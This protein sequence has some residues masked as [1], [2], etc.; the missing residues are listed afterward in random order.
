MKTTIKKCFV[1]AAALLVLATQTIPVA[2]APTTS[3]AEV[4]LCSDIDK[5]PINV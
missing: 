5:K 4:I 2:P 1:I 3:D